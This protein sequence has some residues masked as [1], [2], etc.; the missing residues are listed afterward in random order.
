LTLAAVVS[1]CALV[2]AL[3]CGSS[4]LAARGHVFSHAFG[5]PCTAEPC[6]NGQFKEPSGVAVN[7]ATGRV[8]VIDRGD[9]RIEY[10]SA[11]GAY[12]GQFNGSETPAKE[13]NPG[14]P[15][16]KAFDFGSANGLRSES[17]GIAVDNS[18]YFRH[19]SGEACEKA[20]PSNG[21]VYV[22]DSDGAARVVAKAAVDKFS[23]EGLYLGQLQAAS[24]GAPFVFPEA[25][26][27]GVDA[28]GLVWVDY[29]LPEAG[30][31]TLGAFTNSG[32][33][34]FVPSSVVKLR[35][36]SF[37]Q[38]PGFAVD[39]EGDFYINEEGVHKVDSAGNTFVSPISEERGVDAIAV[40]LTSDEVFLDGGQSVSAYSSTGG[41]EERFGFGDLVGGSGVAVSHA[42]G[43]AYVADSTLNVVDVFSPEPPATPRVQGESV[44]D[45]TGDSAIVRAEIDPRGASTEY[46]FEYG[47]CASV[48]ACAGSPY[49][50]SAPVPEGFAGADF[51]VRSVSFTL[52]GLPGGV[53]YHFRA[54]ARNEKNAPGETVHG[55]ELTFTTQPAVSGS[56]LLDGRQWGMVS[57][58]EKDGAQI[59]AIG[60]QGMI[61][62]AAGGDA[63]AYEASAPTEAGAQ[64]YAIEEQI[65]ST[66]TPDGWGSRDIGIPHEQSTGVSVGK[67]YE[68]RAYAEDLSAAVVQPFGP[69]ISASSPWA[70]APREASGQTAFLRTLLAGGE[71]AQACAESCFHPL[72]TGKPGYANVPP[73]TVFG[74]KEECAFYCGPEFVGASPDLHH[75]VVEARAELTSPPAAV[76][77]IRGLY[78]WNEG[79]LAPVSVLPD[80]EP[81]S[82]SVRL[83]S[84][85]SAAHAVSDDGTRVVWTLGLEKS[86]L[87]L[88]DTASGKTVQL[89]AVQGGAG[90]EADA[91]FQFASSDGSRVFFSDREELT[92]GASPGDL[93]E[94]EIVEAVKGEPECRLSNLTPAGGV[95]GG[96]LGVAGDGSWV[97]FVSNAVLA[98]GAVPGQC[99]EVGVGSSSSVCDLYAWHG[100]ATRLVAVLSGAD[101][102][103]WA[104]GASDT[105][106][107][108]RV[109]P[110]GM[111]LA[112]MSRRELTG[113]DNRDAFSGQP[114]E[115]VY[116][117][118]AATGRVV[119]AS[120][121]PTGARP[122]GVE[123]ERISDKLV[124]GDRVWPGTTWIAA[125]IPGWTPYKLSTALYQ[126]RYLSNGGRLFFNSSDALVP[127]DVNG[128]E[129]VYEYEPASYTN[130]EGK[131]QC[132]AGSAGFSERADGCVGLVS[133]GTSGEESAFLDASESGGDVFFLTATKLAPQDFDT[134]LDVYD[135]HECTALAPCFPVAATTPPPCTTGDACKPAP[136]PQPLIYGSPSSATFSGA[137][138]VTPARSTG[139]STPRTL[140]HAQRLARALR[141]CR[142]ERGRRRAAC[143]RRAR[144]QYAAVRSRG[145]RASRKG[146]RR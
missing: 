69:F 49:T 90:G 10:F 51:E 101:A 11:L 136:A 56:S 133:S 60:E 53:T 17:N 114:D 119:C 92:P 77:G 32:E 91:Q 89:D 96:V 108:A 94:C 67:G 27:I 105:D 52:L 117:Y 40:D 122:V 120:C 39:S 28:N 135:A 46:D 29:A 80:G 139:A 102:N 141:A 30:F 123:Y 144:A 63:I 137:G 138:N 8:Y 43:T 12:E 115:E 140:T 36:F 35:F 95:L 76:G 99:G 145:N 22:L 130:A 34:T 45:V 107:T 93:Y 66:R 19:L 44:S 20:D 128:T 97:Y 7:E 127:Q 70:L 88:R 100:G 79:A 42:D 111:W 64:G 65:L 126:S 5:E 62:A 38:N 18:C 131:V 143:E 68:Y 55:E 146:G 98:E 74:G 112:F 125:N 47:P 57:P 84:V 61:Q 124:G 14:E 121:D 16:V 4:A 86:H 106:R 87:Y 71:A 25:Y 3:L 37:E 2:G 142:R 118:S 72:V 83:G 15:P 50:A 81:A 13:P 109:S 59:S 132:A 75:V 85:E 48:A 41:L 73:G 58:P 113:Y 1:L 54:V 134:A 26:D 9:A 23:P 21:D 104:F 31:T 82:N 116:L 6:G 103:D 110:D 78:E 129:D 24:G 33:N